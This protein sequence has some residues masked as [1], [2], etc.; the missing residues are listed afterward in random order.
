MVYGGNRNGLMQVLAETMLAGGGEVVGVVLP[1][2]GAS[3]RVAGAPCSEL[4]KY[5]E[6][7]WTF[8][9]VEGVEPMN[10]NAERALRPAVL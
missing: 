6:A 3:G 9:D 4:L 8:V 10:N 2:M 5:R 1:R 7:L